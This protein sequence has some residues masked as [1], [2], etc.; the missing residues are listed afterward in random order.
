MN[1]IDSIL[2]PVQNQSPASL[3]VAAMEVIEAACLSSANDKNISVR[4]LVRQSL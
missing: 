3:G 1:L 2:D 4:D